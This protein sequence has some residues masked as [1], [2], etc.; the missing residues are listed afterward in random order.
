[1]PGTLVH[2]MADYFPNYVEALIESVTRMPSVNTVLMINRILNSGDTDDVLRNRLIRLLRDVLANNQCLPDI[3]DD[4][5][6]YLDRHQP[7]VG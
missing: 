1:M 5:S 4:A 3:R 2:V 7:N 6:R